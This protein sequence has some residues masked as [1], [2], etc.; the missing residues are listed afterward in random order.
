MQRGYTF[1]PTGFSLD[2]Y[3]AVFRYANMGQAY[4]VSIFI[5][6]VGTVISVSLCSMAGFVLSR[7]SVKYRNV[8]MLALFIPTLFNPGVLAWY[9]NIVYVYRMANTIWVLFVP[10]LVNVFNIYLVRN[11]Y[12]SIPDSVE[13][14]AKIDGARPFKIFWKIMFPIAL[15]ITAT[16][17]LFISLGYW[18]DWYLA[19][20]FITSDYRHLYPLQ[21]NLYLLWN[22]LQN[23]ENQAQLPQRTIYVA[24]TFVTM[25]PIVLVYPFVQRFF[26]RG[27]MVGSVKG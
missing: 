26:I 15:P 23:V 7:K 25:G 13:E 14:S 24:A 12:A 16:I 1:F 18:N 11:Y 21:Y 20:W 8:I 10:S 27:I 4:L 22:T 17:T 6:V 3:R 9:Y 2:A 5:T 19:S